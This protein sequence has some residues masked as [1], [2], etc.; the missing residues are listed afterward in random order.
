[1]G[2]QWIDQLSGGGT[3]GLNATKTLQEATKKTSECSPAGNSTEVS[4]EDSEGNSGRNSGGNSEENSEE[5]SKE[6]SKENSEVN[7]WN[8]GTSDCL[9][10]T[11]VDNRDFKKENDSYFFQICRISHGFSRICQLGLCR[12]L[13]IKQ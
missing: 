7:S 5:N 1:M 9:N 10:A 3:T 4:T 2:G 11:E 13:K 12:F 6:N 8:N